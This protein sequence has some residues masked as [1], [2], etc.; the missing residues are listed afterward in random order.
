MLACRA[1]ATRTPG[2][3][4]S[5]PNGTVPLMEADDV[6][7]RALAA[8]G[9]G[10]SVVPGALNRFAAF[11]FGRLLPRRIAIR[12]MGRATHRLYG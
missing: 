3:A 9:R 7:A 2:Y 5:R 8:L 4:S 11:A 12:I 1:G 10:P 6:A